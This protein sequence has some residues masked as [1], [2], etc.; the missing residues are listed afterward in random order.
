MELTEIM[1]LTGILRALNFAH[2]PSGDEGD[3]RAVIHHFRGE[4]GSR[5]SIA[6][7]RG[8]WAALRALDG[9]LVGQS[10]RLVDYGERHRAGLRVG[11]VHHMQDVGRTEPVEHGS[12]HVQE[13]AS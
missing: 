4:P 13:S 3:I 10:N 2:S 12:S 9:Y 7:S 8:L 5:R 6:P 11:D 1:E